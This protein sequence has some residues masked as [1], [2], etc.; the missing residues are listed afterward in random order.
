MFKARSIVLLMLNSDHFDVNNT[1]TK[2]AQLFDGL[3]IEYLFTYLIIYIMLINQIN[4]QSIS[5]LN[6]RPKSIDSNLSI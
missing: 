5:E 1:T 4:K 2:L 3:N 6:Y